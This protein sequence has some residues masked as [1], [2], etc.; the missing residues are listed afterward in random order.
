M[1]VD[2]CAND[3]QVRGPVSGDEDHGGR[4]HHGD[5]F[6]HPV[7]V[8]WSND[9]VSVV[10]VRKERCGEDVCGQCKSV[11]GGCED[12][13]NIAQARRVWSRPLGVTRVQ[14]S[15]EPSQL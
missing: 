14:G 4:A 13:H 6:G 15:G 1:D 7:F 10:V 8:F 12:E 3:R 11:V 2:E 5:K 9:D